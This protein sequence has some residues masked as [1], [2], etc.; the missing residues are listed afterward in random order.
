M[1]VAEVKKLVG[2]KKLLIGTDRALAA[3]RKDEVKKVFLASNCLKSVK[4]D[5]EHYA[6]L[7]GVEVSQLDVANDEL[8]VLVKKPFSVSVLALLK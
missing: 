5:V 3:L 8:G 1:T 7:T 2:N 6:K 4:E